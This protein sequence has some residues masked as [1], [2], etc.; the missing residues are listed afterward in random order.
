MGLFACGKNNRHSPMGC[1]DKAFAGK[2]D[3]S[4]MMRI[5]IMV[6]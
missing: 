6:M 3:I 1:R 5:G 4:A 2:G